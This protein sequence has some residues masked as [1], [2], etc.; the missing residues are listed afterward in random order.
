LT[1]RRLHYKT[2][3]KEGEEEQ[4]ERENTSPDGISL[5]NQSESIDDCLACNLPPMNKN[6]SINFLSIKIK[7]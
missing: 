6:N 4:S 5:L 7:I 2:K 1:W 3:R